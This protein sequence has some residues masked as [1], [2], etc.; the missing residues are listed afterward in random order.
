MFEGKMGDEAASETP[1]AS[2]LLGRFDLHVHTTMSDGSVELSEVVD[3]AR[4]RG[5]IVG[6]SDHV[7]GRNPAYFVS[8]RER[9]SRYLDAI[10]S[11]PVLRAA[12]LCW[13]DPFSSSLVAEEI[14]RFDYLIGSNHGFRLPDGSIGSPWWKELPG[15]WARDPDRLME[16]MVEDICELIGAMPIALVAHPTLTP[17]ALY[18]LDPSVERWW[19]PDREDRVIE[20]A[21]RAGVALEISNR[22]RLPHDG[23]LT[24]ALQ[25]G[26]TFTLGS[27]G[28]DRNQIAALDWA[29]ETAR[30]IGIGQDSMYL[31]ERAMSLL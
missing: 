9:L 27:D 16:L 23:F 30:R 26:A 6:I 22:Y 21:V 13:C 24:K 11:V 20:A 8:D 14:E 28:H 4:E 5:V 7:S 29:L 31:P 18:A 10:E 15:E 19:T 25:A 12:E 17:P 2:D 3:I 1:A